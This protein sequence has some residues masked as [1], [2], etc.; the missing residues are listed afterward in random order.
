MNISHHNTSNDSNIF[1]KKKHKR[2]QTTICQPLRDARV[3]TF[4]KF[5]H[6][7]C[8]LSYEVWVDFN[9]SPRITRGN[10]LNKSQ[11][12]LVSGEFEHVFFFLRSCPLQSSYT[13]VNRLQKLYRDPRLA[14]EFICCYID[15]IKKRCFPTLYIMTTRIFQQLSE[16]L[17]HFCMWGGKGRIPKPQNRSKSKHSR[18]NLQIPG[19]LT[20]KDETWLIGWKL[21]LS[22]YTL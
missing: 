17:D 18:Q 1:A 2:Q 11:E 13:S 8:F 9:F 22:S 21:E 5:R 7:F 19:K 14:T 15:R 10:S 3:S 12:C 20:T 6:A 4:A 16:M